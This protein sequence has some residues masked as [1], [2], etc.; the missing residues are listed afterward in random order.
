MFKMS[1][2]MK[3]TSSADNTNNKNLTTMTV[4]DIRGRLDKIPATGF[5][6]MCGCSVQ[7][8]KFVFR[9]KQM[10]NFENNAKV[11][12]NVTGELKKTVST[13]LVSQEHLRCI[14]QS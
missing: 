8:G 11:I 14:K 9:K 12:V 4:K 7:E 1:V 3:I 10:K 2:G 5:D 13:R 6:V